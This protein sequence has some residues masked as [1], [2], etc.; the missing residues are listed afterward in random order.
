MNTSSHK[1]LISVVHQLSPVGGLRLLDTAEYPTFHAI[2]M[3][4]VSSLPPSTR[5]PWRVKPL[6]IML[7]TGRERLYD[8]YGDSVCSLIYKIRSLTYHQTLAPI[9][10]PTFTYRVGLFRSVCPQ[11]KGSNAT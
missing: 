8:V 2:S 9:S 6:K 3:A 5:R 7:S 4:I 1:L 10:N 11:M